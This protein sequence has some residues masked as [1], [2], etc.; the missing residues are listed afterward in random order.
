MVYMSLG[1]CL[2]LLVLLLLEGVIFLKLWTRQLTSHKEE[3]VNWERER[4]RLLNRAMTKE[5]ESYAQMAAAIVPTSH[6]VSDP[7]EGV[8]LSD[9][10]ELRRVGKAIAEAEGIGETLVEL[11]DFDRELLGHEG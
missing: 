8:G 10:E 9:E 4:E 3:R 11:D 5:W 1:F 7:T 2:V 6:L